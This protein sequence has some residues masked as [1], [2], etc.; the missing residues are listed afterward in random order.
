VELVR[1][2][3]VR[4]ADRDEK[5]ATMIHVTKGS[6]T[7]VLS[8]HFRVSLRSMGTQGLIDGAVVLLTRDGKVRS[9]DDFIFFNNP[10]GPGVTLISSNEIEIDLLAVP[11]D[12]DRVLVTGITE[13]QGA[14]FAQ[15]AG[16]AIDVR[17]DREGY[18]FQPENLSRETVLQ[19]VA[20]YR[21]GPGW[22][23]DAIG[24]GYE[25][26]LAAFATDH[27][28]EVDDPGPS[29][30]AAQHHTRTTQLHT[31][32]QPAISQEPV[33]I[34]LMKDSPQ[35]TA[36]MDLRKH[37]GD[38]SWLLTVGLEWDGRGAVY[39]QHG[40]VRKYGS[41]DLDVYFFCRDEHS[42]RYVVISG[43]HGHQGNLDTWPFIYHYGDSRGPGNGNKPATE[44]VR[45]RPTENGDLL[46]NVYQSIDNGTGAINTFGR[47]RVAIRYG[48]PGQDGLPGPDADE[49]LV[50]VG[51][52]SNSYWATVAHIDVQ[53][54][55]LTV[56]G[57]TR[58]SRPHCEIMPVLG[59]TGKWVKE[60]FDAP[61]GQSKSHHGGIGL[62]KYAGQ[63]PRPSR[64][65]K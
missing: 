34:V 16:L 11:A 44:Q 50:Y 58:Y 42:N 15:A 27:G 46:L 21:R 51:N 8:R 6:K 48:R 47:P 54:G 32:N 61:M 30:T 56:D 9:D 31:T 18:T 63:C 64:T 40:N 25:A 20:L 60:S 33:K 1:A 49:I 43:E 3:I 13:A 38:N 4:S 39:D 52:K 41:G 65:R 53:D 19:A 29:A 45:V 26:G 57:K 5:A 2:D 55:I 23:L 62:S 35:Q 24:Q 17:G 37:R 12:I 14:T 22:R 10:K 36:R 59:T 7:D 28:I